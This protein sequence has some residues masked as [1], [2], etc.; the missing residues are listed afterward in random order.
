[1]QYKID[2]NLSKILN[3]SAYALIFT[4]VFSQINRFFSLY[5]QVLFWLSVEWIIPL[6]QSILSILTP[7]AHLCFF[8][9]STISFKFLS[10]SW[11]LTFWNLIIILT[12][13]FFLMPTWTY[14]LPWYIYIYPSKNL[15][16]IYLILSRPLPKYGGYPLNNCN[17]QSVTVPL[18]T[19]QDQC[20]LK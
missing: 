16:R 18:L 20:F 15:H 3:F 12:L 7:S 11:V 8:C 19:A 10:L 1:M 5:P 17:F 6:I 9:P 14:L 4:Q 13:T 2:A